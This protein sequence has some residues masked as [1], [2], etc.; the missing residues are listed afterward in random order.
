VLARGALFFGW[1][2][3]FMLSMAAI[4]LIPT[5]FV[6]IIAYMRLENREPWRLTIPMALC[7]TIFIYAVFDRL[8]SIPWPATLIG[9][10]IPAL[11]VIPSV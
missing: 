6:Y 7:V 10:L 4:G 9:K 11:T 8:L 5:S 2:A 1:F 3:A